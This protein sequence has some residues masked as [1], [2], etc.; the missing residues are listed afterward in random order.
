MYQCDV[1]RKYSV[2][3]L[4]MCKTMTVSDILTQK[5]ISKIQFDYFSDSFPC[6]F[7][8]PTM[9]LVGLVHLPII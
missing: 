5:F 3:N 1:A 4:L 2:G 8:N 9:H 7:P 6:L